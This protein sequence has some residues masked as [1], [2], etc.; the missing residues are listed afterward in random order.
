[1]FVIHTCHTYSVLVHNVSNIYACLKEQ[2]I[3]CFNYSPCLCLNITLCRIWRGG[4]NFFLGSLLC[5]VFWICEQNSVDNTGMTF[6]FWWGSS[7][8][9]KAFKKEEWNLSEAMK[10]LQMF[11][12]RGLCLKRRIRTII[13]DSQYLTF[14]T[15]IQIYIS[16]SNS[17]SEFPNSST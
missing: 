17:W 2:C 12:F 11:W 7:V 9:Y 5:V 14:K 13:P 6:F 15:N 8:G 1:M 10:S 16:I 3:I 4:V